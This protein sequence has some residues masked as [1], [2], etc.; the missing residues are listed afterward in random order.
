MI[1]FEVGSAVCGTALS[2][3]AFIIARAICGISGASMYIGLMTLL[4][5]TTTVQECPMYVSGARFTRGLGTV[6]GLIIGGAFTDSSAG[7]RWSFYINLCIGAV[8]SCLSLHAPIKQRSA[9]WSQLP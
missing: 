6:L 3:D 7:W 8:C 5:V 1:V 9:S 2:I 4:A